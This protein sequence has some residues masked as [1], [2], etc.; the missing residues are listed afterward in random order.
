MNNNLQ[1]TV[2][3]MGQ[4]WHRQTGENRQ[5]FLTTEF[6]LCVEGTVEIE[7]SPLDKY[8]S[9]YCCMQKSFM[10]AKISVWRFDVKEDISIV[11]YYFSPNEILSN[12]KEKNS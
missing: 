3:S 12:Y 11:S 8:Q 2:I 5:L 10:N 1:N 9:N 4:Y 7:K 6:Q